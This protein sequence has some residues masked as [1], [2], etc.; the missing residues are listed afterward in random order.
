[1]LPETRR[2][3]SIVRRRAVT[4]RPLSQQGRWQAVICDYVA[5][6]GK[7]SAAKDVTSESARVF[8]DMRFSLLPSTRVDPAGGA[9]SYTQC[10]SLV[11]IT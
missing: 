3:A 6:K 8:P 9:P 5:W 2:W 11:E 1:V 4:Q 10:S 7:V